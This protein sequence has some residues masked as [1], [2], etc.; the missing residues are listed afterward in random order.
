MLLP[1][2]L[3]TQSLEIYVL[4]VLFFVLAF[5]VVCLFKDFVNVYEGFACTYTSCMPRALAGQK[6]VQ[7]PLEPQLQTI[8]SHHVGTGNCTPVL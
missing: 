8:A 5:V 1:T 7:D 4:W 6:R 2:K 3:C